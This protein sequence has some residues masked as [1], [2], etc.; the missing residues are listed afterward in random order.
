MFFIPP[1]FPAIPASPRKRGVTIALDAKACSVRV[2]HDRAVLV[3][4]ANRGAYVMK[5]LNNLRA[6]MT[7]GIIRTNRKYRPPRMHRRYKRG[8]A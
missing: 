8:R 7:E 5:T 4:A 1:L 2:K 3:G 6:R